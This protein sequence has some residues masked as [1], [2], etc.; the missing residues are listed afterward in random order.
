MESKRE[1]MTNRMVIIKLHP[2]PPRLLKW[3]SPKTT[4]P[5]PINVQSTNRVQIKKQSI[6]SNIL[7][8]RIGDMLTKIRVV[9]YRVEG[10]WVVLCE[11]RMGVLTV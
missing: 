3:Q 2:T 6:G 4:H 9:D 1:D 7:L 11:G 10:W 5:T 8:P